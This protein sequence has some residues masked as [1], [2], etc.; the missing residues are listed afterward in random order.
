M[1]EVSNL[2]KLYGSKV[3]VNNVNFSI[4]AG[5]IV[6]LLGPNGAGKSTTMNIM[7]GYL[8]A[9]TGTVK[10][11]GFDIFE[12]PAAAKKKIGYLP[13]QPPLYFDMTV[14]EYLNFVYDLKGCTLERK[15]HIKEVCEVV[16][17]KDVYN[18]LIGNL[19]KGYKQRVGLAQALINAPEVLILDE[20]TVGLDPKEIIEIRNLIKRLGK[21]RTVILSSH[22]LSEIQAVCERILVINNGR[23]VADSTQDL[24]TKENTNLKMSIRIGANQNEALKVLKNIDGV[25]YCEPTT[26]F[27]KGTCDFLIEAQSGIDI[28][29]PMFKALAEKDMPIL[30]L[31]PVDMTLED[32]FLN[33]VG[34]NK[35]GIKE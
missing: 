27:E 34:E 30:E 17:I 31:K 3:A 32:A 12:N 14:K 24:L 8:S 23:L 16:K 1:I 11:G 33:I 22:I 28:R 4:E 19:S 13:E 2:S 21:S 15:P 10:I 7:T 6:G 35:G 9:N 20:P 5:E 29:R 25:K 26:S 18:R